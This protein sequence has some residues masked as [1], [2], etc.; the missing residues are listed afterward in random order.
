MVGKG[1]GDGGIIEKGIAGY[2]LFEGGNGKNGETLIRKEW[3]K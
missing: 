1:M 2:E 3:G